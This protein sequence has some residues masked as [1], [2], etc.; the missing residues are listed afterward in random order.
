MKRGIISLLLL[1]ALSGSTAYA[2]APQAKP[3]YSG[4]WTFNA[5]R[6]NLKVSP[7]A[8]M[9]LRI[10]QKG[11]EISFARIQVYG[12]QSYHWKLETVANGE[13]E[14]VQESPGYTTHSRVYWQGDSI[15]I[16]Q[17]ITAN[18]G[19]KVMDVV[20]YSLTDGGQ[21]LEALERQVTVG[22]KGIVAN[23]WVYDKKS[24]F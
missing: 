3:D 14:V 23:K 21:T 8:S 6:S 9:T 20:T 24:Q 15:V 22:A 2:Q 18:D 10:E 17:E 5:Q 19:T 1:A 7:P 16:D 4:T 11:R 12:D 13:K